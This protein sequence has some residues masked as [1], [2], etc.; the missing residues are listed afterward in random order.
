MDPPQAS[1]AGARVSLLLAAAVLSQVQVRESPKDWKKIVTAHF[2]LYYPGEEFLPRAREFAAWFEEARQDLGKEFA[3]EIPRVS[4]FLYGSYHD[5]AQA[6]FLAKPPLSTLLGMKAT[7]GRPAERLRRARCHPELGARAFALAEPL[8]DRIF[9]HCQSSDRWNRSFARHELAHQLQFEGL[10]K[11][12]MPSLWV[13]FQDPLI[14]AWFWEGGADRMAGAE[15]GGTREYLRDLAGERLYTLAE[16]FSTDAL[17]DV[18][19]RAVYIEG[20]A[21]L[22]FLEETFGAG[23][24]AKLLA[25]YGDALSV[26]ADGPLEAVTGRTRADL[27]REFGASLERRF[28]AEREGREPPRDADRLTDVRAF[29]RP[30]A[31]GGRRS[32]DGKHVAWTGNRDVWPELYV[33]GKGLLG[34]G[35]GLEGRVVSAPSWSPDGRRLAVIEEVT[36]HDHLLLFS[37]DGGE[38][39]RI[40][41]ELDEL[42]DPAWHPDGRSIA[43]S[44]MKGGRSHL[45]RLHLD[46]RRLEQLTSG[47]A[48][49]VSPAYAPDGTLAWIREEEGRTVLHVAGRGPVTRSW[50]ELRHPRWTPDGKGV[51]LAADV[52]G[53]FDA[54]RVDPASGKALRLTRLRDGVSYPELGP[55]GELLFTYESRRTRDLFQI[56]PE[57]REAPEFDEEARRETYAPYRRPVP[58]GEPAE[59][60]RDWGVNFFAAPVTGSPPVLP[61]LELVVGDLEAENTIS[62]AARGVSSRYWKASALA[63]NTRYWPTLSLG[64]EAGRLGELAE[65]K[66]G[67]AVELGFWS[68]I[69][70]RLSWTGRYRTEIEKGGDGPHFFDS[71]P[72]ASFRFSNQ[73]A[74]RGL[75]PRLGLRLRGFRERVPEGPGRGEGSGRVFGVRRGVGRAGARRHSL[76]PSCGGAAPLAGS[77]RRR[78]PQ[79][80]R[81]RPGGPGIGRPRPGR[82]E[83]GVAVPALPGTLLGPA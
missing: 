2:D 81:G 37:L 76:G 43:V 53:V 23:T 39:D 47:D 83:R 13:A 58:Q 40:D 41:L 77:P 16:L 18:D 31:W 51:V 55:G 20:A 9:I 17:P 14:P 52:G 27:E 79:D 45:Y 71:G 50:A 54:F 30:Q 60:T 56:T 68:V 21:F 26:D 74:S 62:F 80:P 25:A 6:S 34:L 66:A 38:C 61:G 32:P 65:A 44:G 46:G 5:L 15:S 67:P 64:A 1:L 7:G 11:F 19:D 35:R 82:R 73:G 48:G 49:D 36:G 28:R 3:V 8:R 42:A 22:G 59:K 69:A 70:T 63:E 72:T 12:R 10:F 4:V 29:Y 78:D 57:A 75:R 24:L 33:D